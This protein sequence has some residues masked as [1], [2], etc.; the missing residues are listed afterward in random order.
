MFNFMKREKRKQTDT[1]T[2]AVVRAVEASVTGRVQTDVE[3]T[4]AAE[5]YAG[6]WSRAIASA[7]VEP[8]TLATRAVTPDGL[9]MVGRSLIEVGEACFELGSS[10]GRCELYLCRHSR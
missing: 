7:T 2:D 6:L 8:A 3:S 5:I 10:R 1:F 9:S 4:A